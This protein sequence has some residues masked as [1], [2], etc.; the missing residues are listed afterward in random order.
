M[1][2]INF[3]NIQ[4]ATTIDA[5]D[6]NSP[7][8]TIYNDYNGN[9]DSTNIKDG[10][11]DSSVYGADSVTNAALAGGI[12]AN[13]IAI[14]SYMQ[15]GCYLQN[16]AAQA[17]PSGIN[18]PITFPSELYDPEGMHDNTTN[19]SR[20]TIKTSGVY[21]VN[22]QFQFSD[23]TGGTYRMSSIR[24]N[25]TQE[26]AGSKIKFDADGRAGLV[27]F[28]IASLSAGDYV[29]ICCSQDA[30]TLNITNS[31]FSVVRVG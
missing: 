6:V 19:T 31:N 27:T 10:S 21:A 25:S 3:S 17:F 7:L 5:A 28:G 14:G 1:S 24:I 2:L 22:A 16:L 13:K 26:I 20:V 9:I 11:L 23:S 12:T 30:G 4:D 15:S 29:E 18:L 8:N